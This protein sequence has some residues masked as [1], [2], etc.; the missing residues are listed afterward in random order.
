MY[1]LEDDNWERTTKEENSYDEDD[2]L[3]LAYFYTWDIEP[4]EWKYSRKH[5]YTYNSDGIKL[6]TVFFEWDAILNSWVG[7]LNKENIFNEENDLVLFITYHWVDESAS[8]ATSDKTFY[9]RRTI[10]GIAGSTSEN[11]TI[12]PNP[13]RSK[14]SIIKESSG[15]A[16]CS[17]MS[18]AGEKISSFVLSGSS[19]VINLEYLPKGVY[20][21]QYMENGKKVAKKI[22]KL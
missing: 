10:T 1:F 12:Y 4:E 16:V 5:E 13:F 22:I 8:W 2:N 17:L 14:L 6:T 15:I 3:I 19:T 21:L 9:Y 11:L 7:T 20:F 18:V